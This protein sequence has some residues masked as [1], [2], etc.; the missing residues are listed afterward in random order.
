MQTRVTQ[1]L[2]RRCA[3]MSRLFLFSCVFPSRSSFTYS[4]TL[5]LQWVRP[6][7]STQFS[8][9][10]YSSGPR[11]PAGVQPI[12]FCEFIRRLVSLLT[13]FL[14]T[15]HTHV[16]QSPLRRLEARV[17]GDNSPHVVTCRGPSSPWACLFILNYSSIFSFVPIV[18]LR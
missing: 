18:P 9:V 3:A 11:R 16:Q 2:A 17:V 4:S 5:R 10:P 13:L 14:L 12:Y 1:H 8:R 15:C 6:P 7:A